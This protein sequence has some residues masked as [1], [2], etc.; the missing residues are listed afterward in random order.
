MTSSFS[1]FRCDYSLELRV[2]M[3]SGSKQIPKIEENF[4]IMLKKY[5]NLKFLRWETS[6]IESVSSKATNADKYGRR[7]GTKICING[8]KSHL[9]AIAGSPGWG[10]RRTAWEDQLAR[11]PGSD[12]SSAKQS[13][14]KLFEQIYNIYIRYT[15]RQVPPYVASA[16]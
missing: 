1:R 13:N 2:K 9:T 12:V 16:L 3:K 10:R 8:R 15:T 7:S 11:Q 6:R 5:F 14:V 4:E